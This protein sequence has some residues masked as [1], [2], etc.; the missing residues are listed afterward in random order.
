MAYANAIQ[1][2]VLIKLKLTNQ[3]YDYDGW[4]DEHTIVKPFFHWWIW[5]FELNHNE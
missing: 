1:T 2:G 4:N 3:T 5:I